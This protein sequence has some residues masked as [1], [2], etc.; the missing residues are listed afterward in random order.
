MK[1]E[2]LTARVGRIPSRAPDRETGSCAHRYAGGGERGRAYAR[3]RARAH[4]CDHLHERGHAD[5]GC[6]PPY[7]NAAAHARA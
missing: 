7:V 3:G 2:C 4:G 5:R 1:P 6:G